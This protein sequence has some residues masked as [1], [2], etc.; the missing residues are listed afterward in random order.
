MV[1]FVEYIWLDGTKPTKQLRSKTR[2]LDLPSQDSLTLKEFPEWGYDGS[3]TYQATGSNSD[4][5]LRPVRFCSDPT[6]GKNSYLLFCEVM[7][8]DGTPHSTNTRAIL[9]QVVGIEGSKIE[10]WFGFEQE[11]T[12]FKGTTPLGWPENGYP[13]PQGPFYCGLGAE[14]VFGRDIV[15]AHL[16]ACV[17]AG[18]YIYG[19]NAEVMPGQWEFQIGYR[20]FKEPLDPLIFADHL[21]LARW[22]LHRIAE[23]KGVTVS[24]ENK[25]IKGDWNGAGCHTNF[26]TKQMRSPK[27]GNKTIKECVQRLKNKHTEHVQL[28]GD[29][30]DERL[31]G[32]HETCSIEEFRSGVSDRGA[33]I[34][35]P[36][37][38]A[39]KGYGYIEDRRPGANCDP[40]LVC[41]RILTTICGLNETTMNLPI[42]QPIHQQEAV[43]V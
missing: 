36:S 42:N 3:S 7:N 10:P 26:S 22:L 28:Y 29:A 27:E 32:L 37:Q 34:R 15:E 2:V 8:P 24:L 6:K 43:L 19:T 11:Y 23:D 13:K 18:L 4:L 21:Q 9:R 12:L 31:T 20:G 35:I 16:Q 5:N 1:N 40:Y 33:S 14:C 38:V 39:Q 41:A 17:D 25:P 30:L